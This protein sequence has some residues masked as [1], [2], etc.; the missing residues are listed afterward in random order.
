MYDFADKKWA[1]QDRDVQRKTVEAILAKA[2]L[3]NA[4]LAVAKAALNTEAIWRVATSKELVTK[5]EESVLSPMCSHI[6]R[7]D[8]QTL[9]A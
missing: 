6:L 7:A 2:A 9:N 1:A 5:S 8:A 4:Q 3:A